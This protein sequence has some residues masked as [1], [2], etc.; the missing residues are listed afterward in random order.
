M[1]LS[2]WRVGVII[3]VL[4]GCDGIEIERVLLVGLTTA[5]FHVI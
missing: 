2:R 3:M 4:N 1:V 5:D